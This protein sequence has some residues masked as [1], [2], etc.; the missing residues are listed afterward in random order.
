MKHKVI[1]IIGVLLLVLGAALIIL[2]LTTTEKSV[3]GSIAGGAM[4]IIMGALLLSLSLGLSSR[5]KKA[6]GDPSDTPKR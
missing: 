6:S 2:Q 1:R 4:P 3:V 5:R